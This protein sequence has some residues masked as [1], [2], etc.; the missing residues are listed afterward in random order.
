MWR[1]GGRS[2][3]ALELVG[4]G[5]REEMTETE[6]FAQP[7]AAA[8]LCL[9]SRAVLHPLRCGV[10]LRCS[11]A[12]QTLHRCEN[13]A[14]R[15]S[16]A[17]RRSQLSGAVRCAPLRGVASGAVRCGAAGEAVHLSLVRTQ[18]IAPYSPGDWDREPAMIG[19]SVGKAQGEN[20]ARTGSGACG[21]V[22]A[23]G[24]AVQRCKRCRGQR[25]SEAVRCGTSNK[26]CGAVRC[27]ELGQTV[28]GARPNGAVRCG[29]R[30][31]VHRSATLLE[32]TV[33]Y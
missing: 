13:L 11:V 28:R 3:G 27:G 32:S 30:Q 26:R 24:Q 4:P 23:L 21:A 8:Q 7:K 20:S 16:G 10:A 1:R 31:T 14:V 5:W 29:K 22:H 25:C 12:V 2:A 33:L 9:L 15:T 18:C 19:V 17:V 6:A